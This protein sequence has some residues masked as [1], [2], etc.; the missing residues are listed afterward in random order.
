MVVIGFLVWPVG[1]SKN[2]KKDRTQKSNGRRRP[3]SCH[4]TLTK[5]CMW[6]C[7]PDIFLNLKVSLKSV[8][9]GWSSGG[10]KFWPSHWLGTSLIQQLVAIAQAVIVLLFAV[11]MHVWMQQ[12]SAG[13]ASSSMPAAPPAGYLQSQLGPPQY[14]V[15]GIL[16]HLFSFVWITIVLLKFGMG[17]YVG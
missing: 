14:A 10:S 6:G 15:Q 2:T 13:Y 7:I 5:F 8:E 11:S 1:V 9:K 3:L 4:F 16:Q 12:P 17:D